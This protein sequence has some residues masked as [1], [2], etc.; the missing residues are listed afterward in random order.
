MLYSTR[1]RTEQGCV[2]NRRNNCGMSMNLLVKIYGIL[3]SA[4]ELRGFSCQ[5]PRLGIIGKWE[6]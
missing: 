4:Q 3:K 1:A 2:E 6:D 5:T